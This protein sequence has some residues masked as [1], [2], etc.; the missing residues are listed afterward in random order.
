MALTGT[1]ADGLRFEA[2]GEE[3]AHRGLV[4][5]IPG[6]VILAAAAANPAG[7]GLLRSTGAGAILSWRAPGSDTFGPD[8][9][10]SAAADGE[11]LLEDGEDRNRWL[12]VYVYH[13]FLTPGAAQCRVMVRDLFGNAIASDDVSEAEALAGDVESWQITMVNELGRRIRGIRVWLDAATADIEISEDGAAWVSP[14]TEAAGLAFPE[15]AALGS[16]ILHVRRTIAAEAASD[17]DV[18][19]RLHGRFYAN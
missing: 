9:P 8:V 2:S 12:R 18:L 16:D 3:I 10:V 6:V 7:L 19:T 13:E 11:Y 17:P 15:L 1:R 14:T 4:G 5:T